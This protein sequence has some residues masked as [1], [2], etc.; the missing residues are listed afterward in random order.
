MVWIP[1]ARGV[2]QTLVL[3]R[4]PFTFASA[5]TD[6]SSMGVDES[7]PGFEEGV[8]EEG[9]PDPQAARDRLR[10]SMHVADK[11]LFIITW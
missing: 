5:G 1:S 7:E 4:L 8:T 3:S 10:H 2:R 9:P 6:V 11:N